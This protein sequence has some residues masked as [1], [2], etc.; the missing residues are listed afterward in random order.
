MFA[1]KRH[2]RIY[3]ALCQK[4]QQCVRFYVDIFVSQLERFP[5]NRSEVAAITLK[6]CRQTHSH[7]AVEGLKISP[8]ALNE[9]KK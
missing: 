4:C 9:G 7:R 8:T 2:G 1:R 3:F 6:L 5:T